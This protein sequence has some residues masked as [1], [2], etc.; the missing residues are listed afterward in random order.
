MPQ[1]AND[2][3]E[4][5]IKTTAD[6]S[7]AT[8]ASDALG[9]VKSSTDEAGRS[10]EESK[11]K[12]GSLWEQFAVGEL[13]AQ[14][15]EM[16]F[17][18]A[19][20][21]ISSVIEAANDDQAAMSQMSA[22]IKST[23]DASGET[24]EQ[25]EKYAES[26]ASTT[27]TTKQ[28]IMAGQNMISTFTGI[29]GQAFDQTTQAANNMAT[30]FN[31]GLAPSAQQV[32]QQAMMLGKALNDPATGMS[33]LQREGVT[34]SAQQQE[35]IKTMAAAGNQAG[36]QAVMLQELQKEFGNA[37]TAASTTFAGGLQMVKNNLD[38]MKVTIGED[39]MSEFAGVFQKLGP[40]LQDLEPVIESLGGAMAQIADAI[41]GAI[42]V[43]SQVLTIVLQ[44]VSA[45]LPA[46][47]PVIDIVAA[48]A[49]DFA[50]LLMPVIQA[51]M[52]LIPVLAGF[53]SDLENAFAGILQAV[54]P[55]FV[56]LLKDVVAV[57]KILLP[58]IDEVISVLAGAF[59]H[60][61]SALQP[62]L[63][64]I[65]KALVAIATAFAQ[66]LTDL[67]PLIP[68]FTT[69]I[70]QIVNSL[71]PYLPQLIN[72]FLSL[73]PAIV[74]LIPPLVQIITAI[75]PIVVDLIKTI[76]PIVSQLAVYFADLLAGAIRI[77][78]DALKDVIGWIATAI[79]WIVSIDV[80]ILDA[81]KGFGSL[82]YNAGKDLIQG[83]IN[84][85][86]DMVGALGG[87]VENVA[88]GAVDKVK[89]F[90]GIHSPSTVFHEIGQN[91][92]QGMANGIDSMHSV[93]GNSAS[94]LVGGSLGSALSATGMSVTGGSGVSTAPTSSSTSSVSNNNGI[95]I[96]NLTIQAPNN[97][98]MQTIFN[99]IDQSTRNIQR[100]LTPNRTATA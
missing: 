25:Q 76:L 54:L 16:A 26:L 1:L 13:A 29:K 50:K 32:S 20:E 84:G 4:I 92:G 82:L 19:K 24:A 69:L 59:A 43:I 45:L 60:I 47:G 68:V 81:V 72:A 17:D 34:F 97:A 37:G 79:G 80:K 71:V 77:L 57:L 55:I 46:L 30:F 70:V 5:N 87:A 65:G 49:L 7:G 61:L 27:P 48:L 22:V 96:Q 75:L 33:K 74:Q 9:K 42:P 8:S 83:L 31:N 53:F 90:L 94:N 93:V 63:P 91:V 2:T 78:A 85:V 39:F 3:Y 36:A 51:L 86:K 12:F 56:S 99:S 95:T 35:Q 15:V 44:A 14:G 21:G 98:T 41:I 67:M 40:L 38:E 64:I 10:S 23:G 18:K 100:G 89:G 52:P 11:G 6:N 73:L 28:A 88:K 66:V 58:P 62:V